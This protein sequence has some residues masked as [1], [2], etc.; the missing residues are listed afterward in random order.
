MIQRVEMIR[1]KTLFVIGAGAGFDVDMPLGSKLSEVIAEKLNIKFSDYNTQASGDKDI[2]EALRLRA[3]AEDR[4]VNEY[5]QAGV[6][7]S[8]GIGYARSI[9]SYLNA[10][11]GDDLVKE[12]AKLAI[13]HTILHYEKHSAIFIDETKSP[14]DFHERPKVMTSWFAGLMFLLTEGIRKNVD[15]DGI[16]DS[17]AFV[18]FNYDRCLEQFL[19]LALQ[20]LYLITEDKAGELIK[21]LTIIHPYGVVGRLRWQ[22]GLRIPFGHKLDAQTL[23]AA[24]DNIRTFNEQVEDEEMLKALG[25]EVSAAE[26]IIFLGSHYHQQNMDLLT[27]ALPARGG[28]VSVYGTSVGRSGSDKGII[29]KQVSAM[30]KPR[31]GSVNLFVDNGLDCSGLF[32]EFGT[33]WGR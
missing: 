3:K 21:G 19:W 14:Q 4:N 30:L 22:G 9:D 33:A 27:A 1:H 17:V 13:V 15:L 5:R 7:V 23:V 32:K 28:S 24:A 11:T 8:Q 25:D 6:N 10:H 18:N 31:G 20:Q 16:F 2:V 29:Q 12:C 26:R